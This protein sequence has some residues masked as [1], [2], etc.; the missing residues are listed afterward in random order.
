MLI[1]AIVGWCMTL[2]LIVIVPISSQGRL[3]ISLAAVLFAALAAWPTI[4]VVRRKR[5]Q[6]AMGLERVR[7][8]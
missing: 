7:Q 8:G 6:V 2:I 3:W 4:V 5:N 1:S